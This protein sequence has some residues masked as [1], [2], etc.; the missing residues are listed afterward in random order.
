M[1]IPVTKLAAVVVLLLCSTCLYLS[2]DSSCLSWAE[3]LRGCFPGS[4]ASCR[5]IWPLRKF[6]ELLMTFFIAKFCRF[7]PQSKH[8]CSINAN[9]QLMEPHRKHTPGGLWLCKNAQKHDAD[10]LAVPTTLPVWHSASRYFSLFWTSFR[11]SFT[12][13]PDNFGILNKYFASLLSN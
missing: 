9:F 3:T 10:Q 2:G 8:C 13:E 1:N 11:T 5:G 4:S 7:Q 12:L 6:L